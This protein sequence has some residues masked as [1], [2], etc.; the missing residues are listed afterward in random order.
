MKD[1]EYLKWAT[2]RRRFLDLLQNKYKYLYRGIVLDIGGRDRGKFRKPK[3][4]VE[5]WIFADINQDYNPDMVLDVSNMT[6]IDTT[7]IDV[8]NAIE[9]F[10]HVLKIKKGLKEC[11]RVLKK[12]GVLIISIPFLSPIHADPYD[13]QRWT[14]TKWRI[15]LNKIG[16][17]IEKL[18]V[19]GKF[20]THLAEMIKIKLKS[21]FLGKRILRSLLPFLDLISKLDN[22]SHA[23]NN[24]KLNNYHNGY[25]IIAK[26]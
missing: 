26:K 14:D 3:D 24:P 7:S 8:I 13:F 21:N 16:F 19:M 10:E 18:I 11:Y 1:S 15:E 22:K 5:K 23:R 4:Q 20:Y 25:F 12:K 17:K 2:Y 9:L 6:Q